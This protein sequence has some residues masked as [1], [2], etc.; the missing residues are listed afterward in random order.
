MDHA[1]SARTQEGEPENNGKEIL[2]S[3]KSY[4]ILQAN[5]AVEIFSLEAMFPDEY[6]DIEDPLMAYKAV[7]DPDVTYLH[8]AMKENDCE[9]FI[10]AMR[11]EVKDQADNGNFS[12]I[13]KETIPNGKSIMKAVWQMRRKR[14]ITTRAVKKYKEHLNIDG[15]QMIR[16]I[17][18]D[19]TYTPVALWKTIQMTLTLATMNNW[20]TRQLDYVLAFPQAPVERDLYMEIPKGF[21]IEEGRS[22][23]YA[24]KI[25]R[26]IYRQ[27]QAGRVWNQYLVKN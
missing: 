12:V 4:D 15:S 27:K 3:G 26:N 24:L 14:D 2:T 13:R 22:D 16:G 6:P 25:H 17:D 9:Q 18:Y 8:Q 23:N 11:K 19:E 5:E 10:E 21:T 1:K 20:H 7:A